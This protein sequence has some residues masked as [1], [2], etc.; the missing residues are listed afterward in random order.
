MGVVNI[1][2]TVAGPSGKKRSLEFLVD[3]GASYSVLPTKV[4]QA[5]GLK[6]KREHKFVLADGTVISRQIS[7]ALFRYG[8]VEGHSPVVLGEPGDEALLGVVTL[9][10][11]GLILNPFDRTLQPMK[12]RL[13]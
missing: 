12:M 4:W 9:E 7:E 3:S 10:N 11:L 8:K 1:R 6:P 5:L 2:A 13:A